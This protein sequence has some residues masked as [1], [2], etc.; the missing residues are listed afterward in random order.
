MNAIEEVDHY[1]IGLNHRV[2]QVE[3]ADNIKLGICLDSSMIEEGNQRLNQ[4]AKVVHQGYMK[5]LKVV[6]PEAYRFLEAKQDK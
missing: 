6:Q 3:Y 5:L 4:K 2:E 1:V